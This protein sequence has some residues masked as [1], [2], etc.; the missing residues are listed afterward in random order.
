[1]LRSNRKEASSAAVPANSSAFLRAAASFSAI[2]RRFASFIAG[3]ECE[4]SRRVCWR[5][6]ARLRITVG[7]FAALFLA[8]R[9][10]EQRL[11]LDTMLARIVELGLRLPQ[12]AGLSTRTYPQQR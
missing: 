5:L 7:T 6:S 12:D 10:A 11:S 3:L 8:L 1:M 9:L 2:S 4:V